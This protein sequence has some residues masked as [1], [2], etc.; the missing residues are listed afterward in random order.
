MYRVNKYVIGCNA[1]VNTL[2]TIEDKEKHVFWRWELWDGCC[3]D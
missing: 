3:Q 1:A 2:G